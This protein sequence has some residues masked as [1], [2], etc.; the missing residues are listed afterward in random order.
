MTGLYNIV[1]NFIK[2]LFN[3]KVSTSHTLYILK[4]HAYYISVCSEVKMRFCQY[5]QGKESTLSIR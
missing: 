2:M 3:K 5:M 1:S 4:H